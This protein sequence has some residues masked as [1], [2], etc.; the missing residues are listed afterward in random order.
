MQQLKSLL[1]ADFGKVTKR[2]LHG[3]ESQSCGGADSKTRR[4]EGKFRRMFSK[5][6]GCL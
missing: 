6:G 1:I 2:L 5:R 4:R 3:R